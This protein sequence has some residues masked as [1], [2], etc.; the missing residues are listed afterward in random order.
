MIKF[1]IHIRKSLLM[2]NKTSKYFKYAVGEIVL[3]V[4]GILIA[5]QINNWNQER[6]N[7]KIEE[8]LLI[9][10]LENLSINEER[11]AQSIKDEY[12]SAKS[13]SYVVKS[14]ENKNVYHDTMN[15][16]YGRADFS[17]DV[18]ISSTAF[19]A[20]KSKGFD[21]IQSE[22][23]RKGLI[24]LFDSEYGVL[25]SETVRLE[26]LYWPN[27][28]LPLFHKHFRIKSFNRD[29]Q[30]NSYDAVPTNYKA[31]LRDTTY[32]N[33]IKHRGSFRYSG[34]RLKENALKKTTLL[35]NKIKTYL[36]K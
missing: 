29:N 35:K 36:K 10:L 22:N 2:E 17:A 15:Y 7:T 24:D 5:L 8:S 21:I 6:I 19:E 12:T 18:V 26:D 27:A 32:I 1:F 33:M 3:V 34:A 16:H 28:A 11:L 25:L 13:I 14:L 20:I 9:E 23:L 4:I 30:N 31:L